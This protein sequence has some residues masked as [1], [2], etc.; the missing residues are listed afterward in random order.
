[1]HVLLDGDI[2]AYE[3]GFAAESSWRHS[4]DDDGTLPPWDY[5]HEVLH[6]RIDKIMEGAGGTDLTVYLT[7]G[8]TFRDQVAVS[9]PYKGTRRV[10]KPW[11]HRNI[12]VYLHCV[13]TIKEELGLEAD[14]LM[15]SD[16]TLDPDNTIVCSRDKDLRQVSGW[17][18]SWECGAQAEFGP[19]YIEQAGTLK[20]EKGKLSGTGY[21]FFC[22]QCIM[23]DSADNIPGLP[24]QGPTAAW[25]RLKNKDTIKEMWGAVRD[26]YEFSYKG[27]YTWQDYLKEQASL[28]WLIRDGV[29]KGDAPWEKMG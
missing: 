28:L 7:P 5:V 2:I 14:D 4:H 21:K 17:F 20:Y 12:V 13:F 26:V 3:V 8:P 24:G 27:K 18:Y 19:T 29:Y 22:A 15:A 9:K 6:N 11:H 1:M 25:E 16:H 10:Y 23:G